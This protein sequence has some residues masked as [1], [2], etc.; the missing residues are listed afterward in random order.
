MTNTTSTTT[1]T[2]STICT[3]C[4]DIRT[5][6]DWRTSLGMPSAARARVAALRGLPVTTGVAV[7]AQAD[8]SALRQAVAVDGDVMTDAVVK[9]AFP[10]TSAWSP[11]IME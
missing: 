11:P 3:V 8:T 2:T 10:G 5:S 9:G 1:S 4:T 6:H 7:V